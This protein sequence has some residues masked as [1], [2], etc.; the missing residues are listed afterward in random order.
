LSEPGNFFDI[1]EPDFVTLG[2]N[3]YID[4]DSCETPGLAYE[5][6]LKKIDELVRMLNVKV[7][8]PDHELLTISDVTEIREK[9][10]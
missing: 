4:L 9:L 10:A 3:C 7:Y 8:K 2:F 1:E 6:M 5:S